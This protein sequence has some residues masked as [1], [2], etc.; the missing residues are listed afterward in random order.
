LQL[1]ILS[2]GRIRARLGRAARNGTATAETSSQAA[3]P[4]GRRR[5]CRGSTLAGRS[6]P[7]ESGTRESPDD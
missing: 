7:R 4:P 6:Q 5:R 3:K 2:A 1:E